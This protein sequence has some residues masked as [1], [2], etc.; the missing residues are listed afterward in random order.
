MLDP[1]LLRENLEQV[2]VGLRNRGLELTSELEDLAT[3]ESRRRRILPELEGLKREQNATGDE[4][5]RA[6][7]QGAEVTKLQ[8]ASKHRSQQIKQLAAELDTVEKRRNRGLLAIPN[9]PHESVPIGKSAS[10][11][12]EVRRV[13]TPREFAFTP[14]AHWDLGPA[15]GIIDFE[16]GTKIAGAHQLHARS[17]YEGTRVHRSRAA[18]HGEHRVADRHREP[19]EVRGRSLQGWRRL[20]PVPDSHG[21]SPAHEHASQ[22]DP[23]RAGTPGALHRVHPLLPQ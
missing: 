22:R 6:R 15:L 5:A 17:P 9:L 13:G 7:R 8:A 20:G 2:R 10:E 23:R 19:P 14:Q 12:A 18:L 4:V 11:N 1:A 3:L 16:R 21:R